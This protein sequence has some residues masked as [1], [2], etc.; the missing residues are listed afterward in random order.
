VTVAGDLALPYTASSSVGVITLGGSRFAHS[1]GSNNTFL[2][3]NAG[4]FSISGTSNTGTG[5]DALGVNTSGTWNTADGSRALQANVGGSYNTAVGAYALYNNTGGNNTASGANALGSNTTG[6]YNTAFGYSALNAN[7]TGTSNIALGDEAGSNLTT[8]DYNIVIGHLG[9]PG[10][11]N[12]IRIGTNGLQNR[13]IV[14]GIRGVTTGQ[15]NAV[16]VLID[17]N[18]QLGTVSSSRR[19]KFDIE[20]MGNATNGLMRLRA[21]SFRYRQYG[22]NGP[23]QYG[24]IAEEVAEVYPELVARN[25]DGQ[26]ETVMY[27]FLAPMLL[28]EVQK[29]QKTID[30]LNA[31]VEGQQSSIATLNSA[32]AELGQ[33]LQALERDRRQ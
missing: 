9:V 20:G 23:L 26:V 27:Q 30:T 5:A 6:G 12:T 31:T 32:L 28:N 2:G 4:N 1:F 15:A 16:A 11:A 17:S 33:R 10:D 8:G 7:T 22:E 18:G 19:A 21:V 29:Q 25:K 3:V 14:A 24:L 13:A